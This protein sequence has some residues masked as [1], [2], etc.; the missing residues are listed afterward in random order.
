VLETSCL[1]ENTLTAIE[2]KTTITKII[3]SL[4]QNTILKNI[5]STI[6]EI[7][8]TILK[9]NNMVNELK[10]VAEYICNVELLHKL[11]LI[12]GLT[13]KFVATNQSLYV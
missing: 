9:I 13:L 4:K 5:T 8:K 7:I 12:S 10:N 1:P 2:T 3:N 6:K 11:S